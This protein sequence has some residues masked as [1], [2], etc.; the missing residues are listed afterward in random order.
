M[1]GGH[2]TCFGP[3]VRNRDVRTEFFVKVRSDELKIFNIFRGYELKFVPNLGC[4]TDNFSFFD[5]FQSQETKFIIF[6][7]KMGGGSKELNHAGTNWEFENGG[8]GM[9]R[10]SCLPGIPVPT[11]QLSVP[12]PPP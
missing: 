4:I 9:K 1:G 10:G 2:S 12:P 11:F 5:K 8:R 6:L 7:F 3:G